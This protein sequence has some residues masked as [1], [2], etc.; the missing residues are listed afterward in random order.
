[1]GEGASEN[2][3]FG[4]YVG[5]DLQGQVSIKNEFE[6]IIVENAPMTVIGGVIAGARNLASGNGRNGIVIRSS[7]VSVLGNFIGTNVTGTA[8]LSNGSSGVL[9]GDLP[10]NIVGGTEAAAANLLSGNMQYGIAIFA[11]QGI[12]PSDNQVLGNLIGT[13]ITG[14]NALPNQLSGVLIAQASR[15]VI[16]GVASLPNQLSGV[17]IAQASR[18]VIG[19]V[20]SGSRNIISGNA[21]NGIVIY[22]GASNCSQ[23]AEATQNRIE[24]NFIGVSASGT[25]R[26]ANGGDGIQ[27]TIVNQGAENTI[28]GNTAAARNIISG[29]GGNGISIGVRF[30][31]L[32]GPE[33]QPLGATGTGG[34]GI[35]LQN[36]FIG[37]DVTGTACIGNTQNGIFVDADSVSN[38]IRGN[39]IA[40]NGANGIAIPANNNPGVRIAIESNSIVS[41]GALGIDLGQTGVTTND[42]KDPDNGANELQN[43]PILTSSSPAIVSTRTHSQTDALISTSVTGT[44]NSTPNSTFTLQFFFGSNCQGAAHQFTG[45]IPVALDPTI[46]VMTDGDG[47]AAFTYVFQVPPGF[48]GSGF[49]NGTATNSTGN[50]SELSECIAVVTPGQLGPIITRACKGVGKQ[51]IVSGSGFVDGAKVFLNGEAEKTQ[52]VSSEQVIA[53]KAGK[54]AQTSDTLKVRNPDATETPQITY[55]RVNCSP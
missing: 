11:C 3:I 40:C 33:G 31:N 43:F 50:T 12:G 4:N 51:L 36:N 7:Q 19:G 32:I 15:N 22:G 44:F 14:V 9:I 39:L 47:N 34:K 49:V 20:A 2:S 23:T 45:L 26:L 5:T 21:Q 18:N 48:G 17:L 25:R 6:G 52:F 53:F 55:T 30:D 27:I 8:S 37:T 46:Q 35:T 28:G 24:G 16:G 42:A 29:N 41:N 13:D 38:F 1:L 54:R 10:Q